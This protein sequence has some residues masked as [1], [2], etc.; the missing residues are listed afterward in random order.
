VEKTAENC[1]KLHGEELHDL[2]SS[3]SIIGNL[4]SRRLRWAGYVARMGGKE[5]R[6]YVTGRKARR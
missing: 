2:Y 4:K 3:S 1:R 6:L 5:E